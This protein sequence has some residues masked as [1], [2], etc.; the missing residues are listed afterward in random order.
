MSH[1][2]IGFWLA[3]GMVVFWPFA[4]ANADAK[5]VDQALHDWQV[6]RLMQPSQREQK[7]EVLGKVYI[8][9]GLTDREVEQALSGHFNRIEFMM[10]MGTI[11]T[12]ERGEALK[13]AETGKPLQ[14]S[15]GC[16]K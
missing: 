15:N 4:N 14:E 1:L 8:Y 6:R 3:C 10:F 11:K 5:D 16:S 13:D 7:D 9:D 2:R 12:D